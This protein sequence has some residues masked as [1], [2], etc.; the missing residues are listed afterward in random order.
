MNI[1]KMIG[2]EI[3]LEKITAGSLRIQETP[4]DVH[5]HVAVTHV[6]SQLS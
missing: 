4:V 2:F 1:K 6:R 5:P 3:V